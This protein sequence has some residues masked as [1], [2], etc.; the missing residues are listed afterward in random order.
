MEEVQ[1]GERAQVRALLV[2]DEALIGLLLEGYLNDLGITDIET[3][4]SVGDG[5]ALAGGAPF[6]F[7]LLDVNL[8][9]ERSD[10]IADLL[11]HRAG[12]FAFA[13]GYGRDG[14]CPRHAARPELVKP[15]IFGDLRD[16][17][18]GLLGWNGDG[19]RG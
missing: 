18:A 15:P 1:R 2:E 11:T 19:R 3:A 6:D 4:G 5:L 13:T 12:P 9:G 16:V 8:L 14:I 17:V 7:A 10:P